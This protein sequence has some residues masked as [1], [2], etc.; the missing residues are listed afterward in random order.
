VAC[1]VIR[2]GWRKPGRLAAGV[3]RQIEIENEQFGV[4]L[5][6]GLFKGGPLLSNRC[7]PPCTK[8]RRGP[9]GQADRPARDRGVLAGLEQCA[10]QTSGLRQNL[11]QTTQAL[12]EAEKVGV[13]GFTLF[14]TQKTCG[15]FVYKKVIS[16]LKAEGS[17]QHARQHIERY[18]C[19]RPSS[20]RVAKPPP[21]WLTSR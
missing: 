20:S 4:V 5:V 9:P 17:R 1:D 6:G 3:I 11:I 7:A 14:Y 15:F 18:T 16:D 2:L 12:L 10:L 13:K 19:H 8:W 21:A